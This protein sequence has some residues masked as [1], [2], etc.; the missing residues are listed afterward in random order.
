MYTYF[1]GQ[2]TVFVSHTGSNGLQ[3]EHTHSPRGE[4]LGFQGVQ[5]K[6]AT[7]ILKTGRYARL[8][9]VQ[10]QR[11]T[12]GDRYTRPGAYSQVYKAYMPKRARTGR[13]LPKTGRKSKFSVPNGHETGRTHMLRNIQASGHKRARACVKRG[14]KPRL[15]GIQAQTGANGDVHSRAREYTPGFQ[16]VKAQMGYN[17]N[18]HTR[19]G[20][21]S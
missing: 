20:S 4:Q 7:C 2:K 6:T 10:A 3:K 14:V 5:A 15:L 18:I 12:N 21:Y 19:P 11:G 13:C 8:L 16:G 17:R 9:G 1:Q